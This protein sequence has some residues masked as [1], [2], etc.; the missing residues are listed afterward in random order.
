MDA[1]I[2]DP[3]VKKY[4]ANDTFELLEEL[5]KSEAVE[6]SSRVRKLARIHRVDKTTLL[7]AEL[8]KLKL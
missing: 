5:A 7:E 8:E 2:G 4:G 3:F 6:D 1:M